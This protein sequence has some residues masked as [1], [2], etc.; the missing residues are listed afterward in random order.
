MKKNSLSWSIS[1]ALLGGAVALVPHSMV[2][3]EE[4]PAPYTLKIISHGEGNPQA[5]ND[6]PVGM[7]Q[8]R[9]VD[10][11]LK[12][13]VPVGCQI[14]QRRWQRLQNRRQ[15]CVMVRKFPN[16]KELTAVVVH[17]GCPKTRL[18]LKSYLDWR[19]LRR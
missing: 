17:S 18:P 2:F 19:Y 5:D 4:A 3:A 11:S 9:R 1:L 13:K 7:Q 15:C 14:Y 16:P 12:T 6:T 10:V 8:N